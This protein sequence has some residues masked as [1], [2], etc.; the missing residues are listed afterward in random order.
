MKHVVFVLLSVLMFAIPLG[1]QIDRATLSGTITDQSGAVLAGARVTVESGTTGLRRETKSSDTGVYLLPL[2]PIGSYAVTFAM[3]GFQTRRF[4]E[5][6][7]SVG[8]VRTMNVELDV[9]GGSAEVEVTADLAPLQ[10]NNAE[11]GIIIEQRQINAVPLNGRNWSAFLALAPGS[12]NTGEGTQNTIRFNGRARDENNFT[13]D[14]VDAT[15]VKDPRQEANLRLNISLDSIA[16]FRVSSGLYNAESGNGAGAQMNLVSKSGTNQFHGGVFEFFRNDKL[17]AR[18]PIDVRKPP[19][20]LNQFGGNVGGPIVKNKTFFFGNYEGLQQRLATTLT[21]SVPSASFKQTVAA[22]SPGLKPVMEAYKPGTT[23]T[24]QP[25]I[26]TLTVA[27]SQ[28]WKENSGLFK[29]DH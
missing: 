16:E 17:D 9:V 3:D 28:P 8:Q 20:R 7:I 6:A 10:Q 19:F 26:D 18:R 15:G 25:D 23:P 21:G 4:D 22:A 24:T 27:A 13:F 5:I 29:V 11:V 14:G 2:L 1:A 12:T